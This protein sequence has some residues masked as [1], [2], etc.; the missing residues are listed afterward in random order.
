MCAG[1]IVRG[2][3]VGLRKVNCSNTLLQ[4]VFAK[5]KKGKKEKKISVCEKDGD[6]TLFLLPLCNG[7]PRPC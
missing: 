2:E 1:S 5:K 4:K 7:I 3:I 6:G